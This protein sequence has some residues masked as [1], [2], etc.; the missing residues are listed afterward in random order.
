MAKAEKNDNVD[1]AKI[2]AIQAIAVALI[3][4]IAGAGTTYMTVHGNSD[5]IANLHAKT[6]SLEQELVQTKVMLDQARTE[7]NKADQE[8]GR[9]KQRVRD[10]LGPKEDELRSM[11]LSLERM[12]NDPGIDQWHRESLEEIAHRLDKIDS[13]VLEIVQ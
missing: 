4:A 3:A 7:S 12:K 6:K 1:V 2:S 5:E 11:S 10:I 9:V 8:L 13:K